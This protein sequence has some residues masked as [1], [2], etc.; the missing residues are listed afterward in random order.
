MVELLT[1]AEPASVNIRSAI[2]ESTS[3]ILIPV[4]D[5][6]KISDIPSF[7]RLQDD[8]EELERMKPLL[9]LFSPFLKAQGVD[10]DGLLSKYDELRDLREKAKELAEVADRF[11]NHFASKGWI[12]FESL[13]V[14]VQRESIHLASEGKVAQAELLVEEHFTARTVKMHL[15]R[16]KAV[17]AFRPRYSLAQKALEDYEAGRYHA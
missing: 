4:D 9:K 2:R 8:I 7:K 6:P 11:N 13:S 3:A 17:K 1:I 14:E 10:V 5:A 15:L 16:F 12:S